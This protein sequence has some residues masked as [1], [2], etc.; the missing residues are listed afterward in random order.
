MGPLAAAF[1]VIAK[2]CGDPG[3]PNWIAAPRGARNDWC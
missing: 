2:R 3:L 1:P